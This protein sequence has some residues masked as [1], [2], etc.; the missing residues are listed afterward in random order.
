[1]SEPTALSLAVPDLVQAEILHAALRCYATAELPK[2][3]GYI[4]SSHKEERPGDA[5]L[6]LEQYLIKR[7]A[8]K[9]MLDESLGIV[10]VFRPY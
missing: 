9:A 8:L 2:L 3:C 5:A 1:M 6:Y 4:A 7:D 10:E